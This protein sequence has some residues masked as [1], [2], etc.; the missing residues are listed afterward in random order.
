[1]NMQ[2]WI[3]VISVIGVALAAILALSIRIV[4]QGTAV[5]VERLGKYHRTLGTGLRFIVPFI[6]RALPMISLKS[7]SKSP[8]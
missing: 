7:F 1:M 2:T 3:I 4:K 6:D 8:S 5:I